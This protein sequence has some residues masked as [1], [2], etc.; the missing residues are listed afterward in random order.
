MSERGAEVD[1][2]LVAGLNEIKELVEG[3]G[4]LQIASFD[5]FTDRRAYLLTM[6]YAGRTHSIFLTEE[7][8]SDLP[9]M[10]VYKR[11][12]SAYFSDFA[13]RSFNVGADNHF[14]RNGLGVAIQIEWPF[15]HWPGRAASIIRVNVVD[16]KNADQ[17]AACGVVKTHQDEVFELKGKPFFLEMCVINSI[18]A[19]VDKDKVKFFTSKQRQE[20]LQLIDLETQFG[21]S[22]TAKELEQ[23]I[24]GKVLS[25]GFNLGDR[26]TTTWV[27]DPWD[28]NYL[29][30]DSK[31]M[32]RTAQ[33][34][35]ADG[36]LKLIPSG[37]YAAPGNDLL[38]QQRAF[39]SPP[40]EIQAAGA[41]PRDASQGANWD[42]FICHASED[43]EEF[44][45]P[46]AQALAAKGVKVWFDELTLKL[47]D[48]L[49]RSI[50]NGLKFSRFGLV[51]LS[52]SFF[53]KQWPQ[54]ELDGLASLELNGRKVILPV[55][56]NV[57]VD[58]VRN[59]SPTLAD[60]I[61]VASSK[62][63]EFVVEEIVK[64]L[65]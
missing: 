46:L 28:A 51:V 55:W 44:V 49:R 10:P 16:L 56:H 48:R 33:I 31:E 7:F 60:R 38:K 36:L 11:D 54:I 23:F 25:L 43:K 32:I 20:N 26:E 24:L 12:A 57:S 34:L 6:A 53:A 41:N 40:G 2:G 52:P 18:R 4:R 17:T 64:V 13:R 61:A 39:E 58:D 42:L 5:R 9:A 35:E 8:I 47:G 22:A 21:P 37:P 27:A 59:Y 14:C 50:D 45:R 3:T 19:A 29:G 15:E 30:V 62:G 63:I 1:R 65:G